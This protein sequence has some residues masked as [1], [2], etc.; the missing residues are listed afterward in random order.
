MMATLLSMLLW[1][2]TALHGP[3]LMACSSC[4]AEPVGR[5]VR[6]CEWWRCPEDREGSLRCLP[7]GR[8]LAQRRFSRP[9]PEH[10]EDGH[11]LTCQPDDE[12]KD[13]CCWEWTGYKPTW[14]VWEPGW[15]GEVE[16]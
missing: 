13:P 12:V 15:D 11:E 8:L 3:D 5:W 4:D 16:R 2:L 1:G 10:F 6:D 7:G 9:G 14:R